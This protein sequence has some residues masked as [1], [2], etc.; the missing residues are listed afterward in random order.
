MNVNYIQNAVLIILCAS[1]RCKITSA[2]SPFQISVA[3]ASLN[4]S[5]VLKLQGLTKCTSSAGSQD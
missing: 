3:V 1:P 4:L 5:D 2:G